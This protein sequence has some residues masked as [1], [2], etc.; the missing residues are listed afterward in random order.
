M[1][2]KPLDDKLKMDR[3]IHLLSTM[4]WTYDYSD[5]NRVYEAGSQAFTEMA[6]LRAEIDPEWVIWN[7]Y[8]PKDLRG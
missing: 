6:R 5:D 4:D 1:S 2:Y 8:A 7:E 3:Y